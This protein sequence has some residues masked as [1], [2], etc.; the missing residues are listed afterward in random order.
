MIFNVFA[1]SVDWLTFNFKPKPSPIVHKEVTPCLSWSFRISSTT[2]LHIRHICVVLNQQLARRQ[3]L[4]ADNLPRSELTRTHLLEHRKSG[5]ETT[6]LVRA[7]IEV[8]EVD[9]ADL[10]QIVAELTFAPSLEL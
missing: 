4:E 1:S 6:V 7:E 8:A 3:H 9:V 10:L 2:S 5:S